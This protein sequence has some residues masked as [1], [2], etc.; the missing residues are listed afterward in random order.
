MEDTAH[1]AEQ[2]R[3]A[4]GHTDVY[5]ILG[6]EKTAEASAIKKAYMK[7]AL[8]HHPDKGGKAELFQALSVAHAILS[9]PERRKVYDECGVVDD[10][11][12]DLDQNFA[13]WYEYFRNLTPKVTLDSIAK[14]EE[15]YVG[16]A[17]EREDVVA[18]YLAHDGD[19]ATIMDDI[20][21][22]EAGSEQRICDLIDAAIDSKEISKTTKYTRSKQKLLEN[23]PRKAAKKRKNDEPDL[24]V[25]IAQRQ[26]NRA[27]VLSNIL[28][29]Y[30]GDPDVE[31][32][33][34]EED[35]AQSR[36]K[37]SRSQR[38]KAK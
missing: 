1:I 36:S 31:D 26:Q 24:A 21:F 17:E 10:F 35:K 29:K 9:D 32:D 8:K 27:T 2:L 25:I 14:F 6:V 38:R 15:S 34:D 13:F 28:S 18:S 11:E 19:V 7:Q 12:E 37:S 16:S 5:K 3:S 22:A 4:F 33:F 20:M 23:A 30:G